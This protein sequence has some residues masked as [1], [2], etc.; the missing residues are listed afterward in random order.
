MWEYWRH[1]Q[2][3]CGTWLQKKRGLQPVNR[4]G[5]S[6]HILPPLPVITWRTTLP[7]THNILHI[8]PHVKY[9]HTLKASPFTCPFTAL[10]PIAANWM[11]GYVLWDTSQSLQGGRSRGLSTGEHHFVFF[12]DGCTCKCFSC[13]LT[14][15]RA[16]TLEFSSLCLSECSHV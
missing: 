13:A 7:H 4:P 3:R 9:I 1:V 10:V 2:K 15:T 6:S 11:G 14:P 8:H 16:C 12:L 5:C